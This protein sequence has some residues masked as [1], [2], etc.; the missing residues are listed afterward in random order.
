MK[1]K[2]AR[3][4][5]NELL[6][7]V[8]MARLKEN[9]SSTMNATPNSSPATAPNRVNRESFALPETPLSRRSGQN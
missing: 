4:T 9:A 2:L 5:D 8:V 3:R 6:V 1:Q 7:R